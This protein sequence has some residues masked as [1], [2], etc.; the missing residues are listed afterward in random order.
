MIEKNAKLEAERLI[1]SGEQTGIRL[2]LLG[3]L[4]VYLS[5]PSATSH[6]QLQRCYADIDLVGLEKAGP[7]LGQFFTQLGYTSDQ[8]FNALH[9]RTRMI[10]FNPEDGSHVDVFLDRFQMCHALDLRQRLLE[11]YLTLT[12]VDLLITKMQ[13]VEL[14]QKDLK[15]ILAILLDHASGPEAPDKLDCSYLVSLTSKDW[16]L[17]TTLSDNFFKVKEH[18]SDFLLPEEIDLVGQRVDLILHTM[19]TAPK[20]MRWRARARIGRRMDW[21][22]LPDEVK[23]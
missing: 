6:V 20:S 4:A 1:R 21:Y 12:L 15:D 7:R 23:R 16:G 11:G 17:F 9:G 22:D 3:G 2:R 14:N 19:E 18:L 13:I 5:C 8:R 10:F